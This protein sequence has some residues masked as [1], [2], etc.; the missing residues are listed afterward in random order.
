[1][2]EALAVLLLTLAAGGCSKEPAP[3]AIE[4]VDGASTSSAAQ[5]PSDAGAPAGD[6]RAKPWP[7]LPTEL[8]DARALVEKHTTRAPL[9]E[10]ALT[11]DRVELALARAAGKNELRA[12][13][14]AISAML[15][16]RARKSFTAGRS[17][18]VLFGTLHDAPVQIAAFRQL[19][20][21]LGFGATDAVLEQF[22]ADGHWGGLS[23]DVQ[24]GDSSTVERFHRRGD[25][26]AL[27]E[28]LATQRDHNHT[29]WKYDYLEEF[30]ASSAALRASNVELGACDMPSLL[31]A[32]IRPLGDASV[33]RLRELHCALALGERLHARNAPATVAM[34]WGAR[35]VESDGIRRFLPADA[36]VTAIVVLG[37]RSEPGSLEVLLAA[38]IRLGE[39]VL[40]PV[41]GSDRFVLMLPERELR[42]NVDRARVGRTDVESERDGK[43]EIGSEGPLEL[44]IAGRQ[45]RLGT[46][47]VT[48]ALGPGEHAFITSPARG[49]RVVGVVPLPAQ[50]FAELSLNA[51]AA[52]IRWVVHEAK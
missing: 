17:S 50:G 37:G 10:S 48:L 42:A 27:E 41:E 25:R 47:T 46:K 4:S 22:Q 28:L 24:R 33:E 32:R 6:A 2:R 20:G 26:V 35:H 23:F 30:A 7:A 40:F 21:V 16:E 3:A 45:L 43:L 29:A 14:S 49:P 11:A 39:P 52:Q 44:V 12:G 9:P 18:F 34:L 13:W 31:Q 15:R 36:G 19:A 8:D 51:R 38:R 5:R 1:M